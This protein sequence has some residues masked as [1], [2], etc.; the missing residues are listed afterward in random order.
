VIP[1]R[2]NVKDSYSCSDHAKASWPSLNWRTFID[3]KCSNLEEVVVPMR[4]YPV[5]AFC[6][7]LKHSLPVLYRHQSW[8]RLRQTAVDTSTGFLL[9]ALMNE[10]TGSGSSRWLRKLPPSPSC[11]NLS[12]VL[13][14][15]NGT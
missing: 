4:A 6:P 7:Y 14:L 2:S 11:R 8:L 10:Q 15:C 1:P 9:P 12:I 13:M 3:F 5:I